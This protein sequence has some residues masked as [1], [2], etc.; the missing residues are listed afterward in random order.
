M[1]TIL[2]N[3]WSLTEDIALAKDKGYAEH[4]IFRQGQIFARQNNKTYRA[5]DCML[6][7]YFV[8]EALSNPSDQSIVFL[9]ECTDGTKGCLS[10]A[11]GIYADPNLI[12]FCMHLKR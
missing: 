10:S 2:S 7:E 11:Y 1:D 12:D 9:I 8:Q 4:F 6:V 3:S 5:Q